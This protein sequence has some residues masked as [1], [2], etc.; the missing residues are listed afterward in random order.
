MDRMRLIVP[1]RSFCI[2]IYDMP[3]THDLFQSPWLKKLGPAQQHILKQVTDQAEALHLSV[4]L[5][6]GVVRDLILNVAVHDFDL[7]VEKNAYQLASRLKS[8]HQGKIDH[9][10]RFGT[11]TWY[12]PPSTSDPED[13]LPIS[14]SIDFITARR[15]E[16][17]QPAALPLI[18][19]STIHDDLARRDFTINALAI[20][21]T[22]PQSGS[23]LDEWNGW[24]DLQQGQIRI[25]H[26]AS[27]IDDPTRIF[28][29]ARFARRF[30]FKIEKQTQD[31]IPSGL[32]HLP[33]VSGQRIQHELDLIFIESDPSSVLKDLHT[34]QVLS[35]IHPELEWNTDWESHLSQVLH[36]SETDYWEHQGL[37]LKPARLGY[38]LWLSNFQETAITEITR[39]LALTTS[40]TRSI[41]KLRQL[42]TTQET[43]EQ[44]KPG[45]AYRILNKTP[46]EVLYALDQISRS[47]CLRQN[48]RLYLDRW[49]TLKPTITGEDLQVFLPEPGPSYHKI[50]NT[51][52]EAWLNEEIHNDDEEKILLKKLLEHYGKS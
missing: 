35:A 9:H 16:Y 30:H 42:R 17:P 27:F 33:A 37:S 19:P 52:H 22:E 11:A 4:Y 34:W 26:P 44:M 5:V 47:P 29:A 2:K 45:Q 50:L 8:A 20:P 7:V 38:I 49:K 40:L 24:E 41:L 1:P 25:L 28:R 36:P 31:L 32:E 21:L 14:F 43:W 39:R 3:P 10:P 46:L 15:E 51:L 12:P 48:I 6:G 13:A 23:L 18:T